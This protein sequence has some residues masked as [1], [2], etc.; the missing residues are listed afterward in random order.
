MK[1]K[2]RTH[3]KVAWHNSLQFVLS[4]KAIIIFVIGI[5]SLLFVI[6]FVVKS[7]LVESERQLLAKTG[8]AV[9]GDI[10]KIIQS[11]ESLTKSLATIAENLPKEDKFFRQFIPQII[12]QPGLE[13]MVA[14]GGIWPEPNAFNSNKERNSF[15]WARN[16]N[17][18]LEFLDDYNL[19]SGNGYHN[20][21]WYVPVKYMP[22]DKCY[23]SQSYFDPYS[24]E[25][26]VT[27][28]IPMQTNTNP[29]FGVATVD[30]KL[31][32][33]TELLKNTTAAID[34]YAFVVDRNNKFLTYPDTNKAKFTHT[35]QQGTEVQDFLDVDKFT[36]KFAVFGE[37]A[38][39]LHSLNQ[40]LEQKTSDIEQVK[41][42]AT[43]LSTNSYQIDE[44][45]AKL[46]SAIMLNPEVTQSKSE[47]NLNMRVADDVLL[48]EA[49]LVQ[50]FVL[51]DTF[52]KLVLVTPETAFIGKVDSAINYILFCLI[53]VI[54]L[55]FI[56]GY[57]LVGK[58][59]VSPFN[60]LVA[61]LSLDSESPLDES[62]S[63]EFGL[64]ARQINLKTEL[65]RNSNRQMAIAM[66]KR[67]RADKL[68][69]VSEKRFKAIAR[70]A[71]DAII[72]IDESGHVIDW[73]PAATLI[74]G[75]ERKDIIG[76][77]YRR[78]LVPGEIEKRLQ[79][80]EAYLQGKIASLENSLAQVQAVRDDGLIFTAEFSATSWQTEKG[81]FF[82]LFLRDISERIEAEY[83]LRHQ[84]LH[85]PL[86]ELPNRNL[87]KDRLTTA[88]EQARRNGT[89]VA[90]MIIDLDNF[91]IINDTLGHG[92]GDK[93]LQIVAQRVNEQKRATD[94][95]ARL[96]GDEF[97]VVQTNFTEP[98]DAMLFAGKLR[99]SIAET[100]TIEENIFQIGC[101]VGVTIYPHDSELSDNLLRNAD[102]AMYQAKE[103]GRNSIRFFVEEMDKEIQRRK[104]ILE[105]IAIAIE[106]NQFELH[107]QPL[108]D[109]QTGK[110][111]GAEALIRWHHPDKGF[112]SPA[113]FIP[114]AE[115]SQAINDIG[116]WVVKDV[117]RILNQMDEMSLPNINIA[118]NISPAQFR[119]ENIFESLSQILAQ[120]NV[121]PHRIECE[122]TESATMENVER[123]IQ[124]MH[125]LRNAG[126]ELSIDDFGTGYSSLSFLKRFPISKIKIDRS[127]VKDVV[128]D[129]DSAAI[130]KSIIQMGHS[131]NLVVL[132]EGIET[133]QQHDWLVEQGCDMMQ[134]YFRAKP[135]PFN[136]F[137]EWLKNN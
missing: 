128:N 22:K 41:S 69:R 127:F 5:L 103:E 133:Q 59:I 79:H 76:R 9:A 106:E 122:I 12:D 11:T 71:P 101:S 109:L 44:G 136:S 2:S 115:Q 16:Q 8:R 3:Q 74:F 125:K 30:I 99:E 90:V 88:M 75:Y 15:F 37:I 14:G 58:A 20:E 1:P 93:L 121:S 7:I 53:T 6:V 46:L 18:V 10:G 82:S 27:C 132:A 66:D 97:G 111:M 32:G 113:E 92:V 110:T 40:Q 45:E 98:S 120:E 28:T 65:L 17:N 80:I 95:I 42:L 72:S 86:T 70:T 96:G 105:D 26:M 130:A 81:R 54:V 63:N 19:A 25:P 119:R 100:M 94:T 21:E 68:R 129:E 89:L 135:M 35:D 31:S 91:K 50:I 4:F 24:F 124:V 52:W 104:H 29:F 126:F 13:K 83:K 123:V 51:P 67:A 38:G 48:G 39:Q 34:G 73:N 84:A 47:S 60:Q 33:L 55:I 108:L 57:R 117:C 85:D 56:L 137:V 23:W 116:T 118:M 77:K 112:I 62:A 134:G 64:V 87:F 36:E 107:L 114:I 61:Q 49:V 131:M 78:L 102:I 43:K